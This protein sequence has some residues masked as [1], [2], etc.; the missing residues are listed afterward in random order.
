MCEL[1][2]RHVVHE[3]L[4]LMRLQLSAFGLGRLNPSSFSEISIA[5]ILLEQVSLR[6]SLVVIQLAVL[7]CSD[8]TF[9]IL[10]HTQS[11]IS[12]IRY[13]IAHLSGPLV[14]R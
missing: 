13:T 4:R 3:A 11:F 2:V 1:R 6:L 12:P 7:R 10:L 8:S 9:P 5:F 14:S